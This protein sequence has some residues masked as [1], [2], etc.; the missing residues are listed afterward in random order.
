MSGDV[1]WTQGTHTVK[2]R[3]AGELAADQLPAARSASSGIFTFNGQYTGNPFADFLLGYASSASLS[4]W[5]E[6]EFR[7]PLHPLLRAGRLARHAAA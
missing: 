4:K 5:A 1:T 6:L 7:S 2:G 3:R